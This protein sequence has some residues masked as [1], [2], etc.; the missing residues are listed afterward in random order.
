MHLNFQ[1][2]LWRDDISAPNLAKGGG[3]EQYIGKSW[4][5]AEP[6]YDPLHCQS[7]SHSC[8]HLNIYFVHEH[9]CRV[10]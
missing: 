3:E 1:K 8:M 7:S 5:W 6:W 4:Q 2:P 10:F 9:D